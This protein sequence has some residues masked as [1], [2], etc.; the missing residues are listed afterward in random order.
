MRKEDKNTNEK[1]T[2]LEESTTDTP[3]IKQ[4]QVKPNE[5]LL[6]TS[7]VRMLIKFLSQGG[8]RHHQIYLPLPSEVHA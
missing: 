5:I 3:K 7:G 8:G 1:L 6:D 2:L 4:E